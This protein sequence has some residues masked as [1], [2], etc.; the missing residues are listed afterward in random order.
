MMFDKQEKEQLRERDRKVYG[1]PDGPDFEF[2]VN[3]AKSRGLKGNDIYE[4][5]IKGSYRT[6]AGTDEKLL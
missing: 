3:L 1:N 5:I 2:L 6:D 4:A